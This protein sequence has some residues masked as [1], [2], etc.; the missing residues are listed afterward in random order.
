M[1]E[2]LECLREE[3]FNNKYEDFKLKYADEKSVLTYVATG[4]ARVGCIWRCMWPRYSRLYQH[5]YMNTT[6][7][8]ERLW[9]YIKYILLRKK[10]NRR[11]DTLVWAIIGK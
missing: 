4:W 9:H 11:L 3:D 7:L 10:V 2:L 6:N 8:V 5:V 1:C